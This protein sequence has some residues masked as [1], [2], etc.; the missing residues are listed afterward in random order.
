MQMKRR[1]LGA[2]LAFALGA[3]YF[4]VPL[5]ATFEFSLRMRRG[6]YTFDAYRVGLRRSALPGRPSAIR[7]SWRSPPSWSACCSSCR[8]P[9]GSGCGCRGCGR[10]SSS[11]RCC[12]WSS[13][14]SSSC[15]AIS[16]STTRPRCCRS[17]SSARGT[18]MLLVFGY[19]T[20]A[21]P[22][23]YRAVD[24]GLRAIDVRT[25]TEAA[26]SL[27][28]SWPTILFRVILPNVRVG[29]ALAARS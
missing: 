29:G 17:P 6:E 25:L 13:R 27:G 20:L 21:L 10:S 8:P 5:I 14:R 2:W 22:Y 9:T 18:D 28:A 26:Q 11:S 19:V 24:T 16:G 3:L 15:S 1:A 4:L 12:R 7:R 23:M